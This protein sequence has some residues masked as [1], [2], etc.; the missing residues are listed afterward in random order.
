M[1]IT[2]I[3]TSYSSC[4]HVTRSSG[5]CHSGWNCRTS[6]ACQLF[7]RHDK[8]LGKCPDCYETEKLAERA[9]L[10]AQ[11]WREVAEF[12]AI[13]GERRNVS[14]MREAREAME[15]AEEALKSSGKT[16]RMPVSPTL[17]AAPPRRTS[18]GQSFEFSDVPAR[19]PSVDQKGRMSSTGKDTM[20]INWL[21]L[22]MNYVVLPLIMFL[23]FGFLG[24]IIDAID[25][26]MEQARRDAFWR[27]LGRSLAAGGIR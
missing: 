24:T 1:C 26:Q 3:S 16:T 22:F 8:A 7:G 6:W 20:G 17:R 18:Y 9:K 27:D 10:S 12:M 21:F 13:V 5:Q 4:A 2:R 15:D 19:R 23:F 25:K 14:A 11:P